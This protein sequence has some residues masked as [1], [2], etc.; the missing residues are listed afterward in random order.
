MRGSRFPWI[1][2]IVASAIGYGSGPLFAKWIYPTGFDWLDLLAW[3][4]LLAATGLWALLLALPT[5]RRALRGLTRR[6]ATIGILVGA[7]F[8]LNAST[9][10][11]SL[12]YI[13][14]S[15]AGLITYSYPAIVAVLSIFFARSPS[16]LRPWIALFVATL[17][18]VL[19]V[20]GIPAAKEPAAIGLVLSVASPIIYSCYIIQIGRAHV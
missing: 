1:L 8:T 5:G 2:A 16:G 19:G 4:H 20:G 9:Y 14:A 3:R 12:R 10:F 13:D 7:L 11:A 15:L 6:R 17:G 18:V